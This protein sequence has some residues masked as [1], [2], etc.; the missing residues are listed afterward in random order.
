MILHQIWVGSEP[1]EHLSEMTR[2]WRDNHPEWEYVLWRDWSIDRFDLQNR[3]LYDRAEELVPADAV[4]QYR[5]DIARY[6]ILREYGGVYADMDTT[7]QRWC[8][9]L[10]DTGNMVV[11]WEVQD[12]FIGNTVIYSPAEHE[13]L[14][15]VINALPELAE[16][17]PMR[18]NKLS[19]PKAI[20]PLLRDRDDVTTLDQHVFYP[21]PWDEPERST[22]DHPDAYVVHHWQHQRDLRGIQ[23]RGTFRS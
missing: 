2:T 18:P 1:P 10:F 21:V 14:S 13:A 11:G 12:Q 9:G 23:W 5:A 22:E 16:Q 7:C 20:T 15:V 19:G 3:D 8:G 6:E 17:G 4:G